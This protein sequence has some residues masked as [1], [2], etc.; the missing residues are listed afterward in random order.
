MT[1]QKSLMGV[2][3]L[4]LTFPR[5]YENGQF[6]HFTKSQGIE[7]SAT[8]LFILKVLWCTN[9][10]MQNMTFITPHGLIRSDGP[11]GYVTRFSIFVM[12]PPEVMQP[13]SANMYTF[14]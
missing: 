13:H 7:Q 2:A 5:P 1:T 4:L 11:F 12:L 6:C 8:L 10:L 14:Y 3:V 9:N